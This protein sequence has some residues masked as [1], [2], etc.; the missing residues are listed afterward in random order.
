MWWA[1]AI[2]IWTLLSLIASPLIGRALAEDH[3]LQV[4]E[5]KVLDLAG[6]RMTQARRLA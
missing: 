2:A 1:F 4:R 3:S 6:R 5:A